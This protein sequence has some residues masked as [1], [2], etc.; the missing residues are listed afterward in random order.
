MALG[1]MT[2]A[3]EARRVDSLP[4]MT[5][6]NQATVAPCHEVSTG[7]PGLESGQALTEHALLLAAIFGVGALAAFPFA[8]DLLDALREHLAWIYLVVEAPLP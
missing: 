5:Q 6:R 4:P 2:D 1:Q 7:S 8:K 3:V